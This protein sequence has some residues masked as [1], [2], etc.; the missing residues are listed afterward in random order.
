MKNSYK[1]EKI[2]LLTTLL[3]STLLGIL[4]VL[5]FHEYA[6]ITAYS[7]GPTVSFIVIVLI[8]IISYSR[9]RNPVGELCRLRSGYLSYDLYAVKLLSH[10]TPEYAKKF[11]RDFTCVAAVVPIS[12]IPLI[13]LISAFN[14][15]SV[16]KI[17]CSV[18]PLLAYGMIVYVNL[19]RRLIRFQNKI[20]ERDAQ[21]E[22]ERIEQEK[23]EREG[24]L[25]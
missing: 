21:R 1:R 12:H 2:I 8:N 9:K 17:F 22:K 7:I 3:T 23:R 13:F 5:I 18:I 16:S 11:Y 19:Y 20:K 24:R 14:I 15:D 10:F 4:I 25:K 6:E